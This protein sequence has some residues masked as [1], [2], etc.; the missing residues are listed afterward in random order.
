[1]CIRDSNGITQQFNTRN[2]TSVL[3]QQISTTTEG[4]RLTG[5]I[6]NAG[7]QSSTVLAE[8]MTML[9]QNQN[10]TVIAYPR[11]ERQERNGAIIAPFVTTVTYE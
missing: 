11:F 1:M 6:Q 9:E 2:Q 10:I 8:F 4:Y 7:L 5:E 3:L